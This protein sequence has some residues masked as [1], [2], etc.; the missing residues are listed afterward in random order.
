VFQ[1]ASLYSS[2]NLAHFHLPSMIE[3]DPSAADYAP[4]HDDVPCDHDAEASNPAK[5]DSGNIPAKQSDSTV[6]AVHHSNTNYDGEAAASLVGHFPHFVE[7]N[8][9]VGGSSDVGGE[10]G[11]HWIGC[12]F[13]CEVV[14]RTY[15]GRRRYDVLVGMG[16]VYNMRLRRIHLSSS[17]G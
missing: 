7:S 3:D 16:S 6:V 8:F 17:F 14:G 9:R 15:C 1:I 2:L 13:G 5:P 10:G 11:V 4:Q 12:C